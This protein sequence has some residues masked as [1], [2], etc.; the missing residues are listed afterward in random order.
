MNYRTTPKIVGILNEIYNDEFYKQTPYEKNKDEVMDFL[1]EV[2]I[3]TDIEKSVSEFMD[4]YNDSLILY[5]S[6]KSRFYN[7]GVGE[8]YDA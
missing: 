4:Q 8:L 7:I 5:L 6:N 2:R 1:P 3:V